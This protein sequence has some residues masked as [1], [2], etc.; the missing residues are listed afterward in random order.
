MNMGEK[1]VHFSDL[2]GEMIEN[3]EELIGV[4]VTEHPDLDQPVRLEAMPHELDQLGKLSIAGVGL[5]VKGPG[6]KSQLGTC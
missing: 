1:V 2:S 4:V 6:T 5:E 3:P